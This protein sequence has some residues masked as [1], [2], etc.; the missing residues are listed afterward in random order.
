MI[1]IAVLFFAHA[2]E[3]AGTDR[4]TFDL[5]AGATTTALLATI[6]DHHPRLSVIRHQLRLAVNQTYAAVER[7]LRDGDEVAVLPPVSGG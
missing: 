2:R 3:L 5:A 7:E 6:I 1:R 4:A